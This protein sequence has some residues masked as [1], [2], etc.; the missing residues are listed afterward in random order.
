[1]QY[2]LKI[3]GRCPLFKVSYEVT[4]DA[5]NDRDMKDKAHKLAEAQYLD[6]VD[7]AETRTRV[8][9]RVSYGSK[10]IAQRP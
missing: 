8:V 7:A 5:D 10:K 9:V 4:I 6:M 2:L 1:M 3:W